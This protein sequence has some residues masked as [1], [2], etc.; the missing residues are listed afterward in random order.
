MFKNA[1][2]RSRSSAPVASS[3]G[4]APSSPGCRP[5]PATPKSGL[6]CPLAALPAPLWPPPSSH[7]LPPSP[8]LISHPAWPRA[9]TPPPPT[10]ALRSFPP[11]SALL[12]SSPALPL[13]PSSPPTLPQ[14]PLGPS[15]FDWADSSG[16]MVPCAPPPS[17]TPGAPRSHPIASVDALACTSLT[18]LPSFP[19]CPASPSLL[20]PCTYIYIE[21]LVE[22][23]SLTLSLFTCIS[24]EVMPCLTLTLLRSRA[25]CL[26]PTLSPLP[27]PPLSPS[28]SFDIYIYRHCPILCLICIPSIGIVFIG[29]PPM[30][31]AVYA[32]RLGVTT[33]L[34]PISSLSPP[35]SIAIYIYR[36]C[37]IVLL[38][39]SAT[40]GSSPQLHPWIPP[41][42][43]VG[44]AF[45]PH[46]SASKTSPV[47]PLQPPLIFSTFGPNTIV[48][49][50]SIM[51]T[52]PMFLLHD[53][54]GSQAPP[55]AMLVCGVCLGWHS[56]VFSPLPSICTSGLLP[57]TAT[58]ITSSLAGA[59]GTVP[60]SAA[61]AIA[62]QTNRDEGGD[63]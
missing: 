22:F 35:L 8:C 37:P 56:P 47:S 49:A 30:Q 23:L 4:W 34:L 19:S 15:A 20:S 43:L 18:P 51:H 16:A 36:K 63:R 2:A 45:R 38:S 13:A 32:I 10:S 1:C 55:G 39:N 6:V 58:S 59:M 50:H 52:P 27:L 53:P 62:A 41:I 25:A 24:N 44:V 31:A 57:T 17:P 5:S 9:A 3:P 12:S 60:S 14:A 48:V 29:W 11:S 54:E 7:R 61:S 21:A 26:L 28:P 46:R 42:L 33:H 40:L